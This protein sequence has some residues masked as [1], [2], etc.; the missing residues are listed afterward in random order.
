MSGFIQIYTGAGKGKTTA[1]LGLALRA[2]GAGMRVFIAQF[3]KG[4]PYSEHASL[5]RLA[6]EIEV[7]QF[8]LPAFVMGEPSP[9][10]LSAAEE[11]VRAVREAFASGRYGL[12]I[13]DEVNLLPSLGILPLE[14][15][16]SLMDE[17]PADVELV[18][19]GRDADVR[20]IERAD[21][22]TEMLPLKH[23]YEKGVPA[24]A[25]IEK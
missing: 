19:T 6:P 13:L 23:Y 18:L 14:T 15:I 11:G 4:R 25:G 22:V 20:L 5:A 12:V 10:D 21:L 2:A 9:E 1:A 24:R 7:R 8:G 16:L 17:K 3:L